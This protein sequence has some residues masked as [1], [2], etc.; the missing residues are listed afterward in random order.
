MWK[1]K[2]GMFPL[3]LCWCCLLPAAWSLYVLP[4]AV[5][6]SFLVKDA[7]HQQT[8]YFRQFEQVL[9]CSHQVH[10]HQSVC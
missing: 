2:P 3:Q 5:G 8:G 6:L 7:L 1:T 9:L 4:L 10:Q